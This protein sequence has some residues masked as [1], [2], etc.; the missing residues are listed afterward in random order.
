M[1]PCIPGSLKQ[2][3]RLFDSVAGHLKSE[4]DR[5]KLAEEYEDSH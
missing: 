3:M 2:G 1:E 5:W 4:D